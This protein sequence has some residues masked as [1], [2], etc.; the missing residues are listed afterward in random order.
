MLFLCKEFERR[1]HESA[2][3]LPDDADL[4]AQRFRGAGIPVLQQHVGRLRRKL[5]PAPHV[6]YAARFFPEAWSIRRVIRKGQWD[7]V[8]VNGLTNPQT[9][10]G[11]RWSGARIV[12]QLP[13]TYSPRPLGVL[14]RRLAG[15]DA[16][17]IAPANIV[18][19]R[20]LPHPDRRP[21]GFVIPPPVQ[22]SFFSEDAPKL[23]ERPSPPTVGIVS[24]LAHPKGPDL[25]LD[26]ATG[27]AKRY[28]ELRFVVAGSSPPGF[29][30]YETQLKRQVA[31]FRPRVD[32]LGPVSDVARLM[33][34]L[35]VLVF[36]SRP[37][38]DGLPT[39]TLEAMASR[40]PIVA[41][42]V[43]GVPE[44]LTH[45][46]NALLVSPDGPE[47]IADAVARLLDTPALAQRLADSAWEY[48]N[49]HL[50]PEKIAGAY[51]SVY[52]RLER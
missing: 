50:R 42:R 35:Q 2:V 34:S 22:P 20:Y 11:A 41:T 51:L 4:P 49:E 30:S 25:F 43:A 45:E 14:A 52:S 32:F 17:F 39:V 15:P 29:E 27:L 40:T 21:L 46:S 36:P 33:R 44:V 38:L 5:S 9:T 1:G 28:P 18:L 10:L 8:T 47:G 6:N 31:D 23:S 26:A 3:L 48:A 37:G 19:R 16:V 7:V 13:D 12:H 24:Q